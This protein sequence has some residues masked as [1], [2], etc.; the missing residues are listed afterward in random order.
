MS[1][2]LGNDPELI[3][4]FI[5]SWRVGCRRLS[6]GEG[7]LEALQAPNAEYTWDTI[8]RI[9]EKGIV[10]SAG[11]IELDAIVCATGFDVSFTPQWK[12]RGLNGSTL[13]KW[14]DDPEGYLGIFAPN[15]PNY[16]IVDGPNSPVGHGSFLSVMEWA[17][18]Y[19]IRWAKKMASEDIK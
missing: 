4:K 17:T 12:M 9:T 11:E 8:Q 1:E 10:T 6:P 13:D 7:Y 18:E 19:I 5:P 3:K 2:R 15:M 16:F 14:R